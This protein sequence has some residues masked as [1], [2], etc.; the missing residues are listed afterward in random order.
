MLE[1]RDLSGGYGDGSV[2]NGLS[3]TVEEGQVVALLGRNGAGK[4]TTMRAIFNL[5]PQLTGS[6]TLRGESLRD[7]APYEVSQRGVA[8]VPQGRRIFPSLT[9]E[10]NL[11]IGARPPR[12][13]TNLRW[14]VDE[15]YS[16]F[17][18][19]RERGRVRGTL[20][21]GGEQQM[22]TLARSLMTQPLLLLCD[23]PSEGL[24][25]VMV[26]RVREVLQ[27]LRAAGLSILLAEQNLDLALS[28]ADVAYII[29]EG[30]VIWH[31]TSAELLAN[32][33]VQ[34]TYLGIRIQED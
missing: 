16:L 22:L 7:L 8:L 23:E 27:R 29:E 1:L 33:D 13:D 17:P 15:I 4:T 28:V 32:E 6:V 12:S 30:R 9:V 10:E 24:A 25:P 18:V 19:L 3:L 20:L 31:G 2:L 11:L 5:L 34:A 21:S 26:D 14:T